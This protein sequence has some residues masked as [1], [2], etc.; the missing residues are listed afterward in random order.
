MSYSG[1]IAPPS[2]G[3]GREEALDEFAYGGVSGDS[4]RVSAVFMAQ[5]E[6]RRI[7]LDEA[8]LANRIRRLTYSLEMDV[9]LL[10]DESIRSSATD[11]S[12]NFGL[13][14]LDLPG[15]IFPGGPIGRVWH[16]NIAFIL[17]GIQSG[18]TFVVKMDFTELRERDFLRDDGELRTLTKELAM[19]L[20]HGYQASVNSNCLQLDP[21][22]TKK[23]SE[24]TLTSCLTSIKDLSFPVFRDRLVEAQK[25]A[26]LPNL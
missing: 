15:A 11:I 4:E 9:L 17:G 21:F 26:L 22:D 18:K 20:D 16:N 3:A 8:E 23:C 1:A 14:S 2:H 5:A 6:K 10:G 25:L 24:A 19:I 13:L 7:P 12:D